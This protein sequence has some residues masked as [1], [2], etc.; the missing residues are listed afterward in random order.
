MDL[1]AETFTVDGDECVVL[2]FLHDVLRPSNFKGSIYL[3]PNHRLYRED[4]VFLYPSSEYI[5]MT[6][7]FKDRNASILSRYDTLQMSYYHGKLLSNVTVHCVSCEQQKR[8]I[9]VKRNKYYNL[10]VNFPRVFEAMLV[11]S[12]AVEY[13]QGLFFFYDVTPSFDFDPEQGGQSENLHR[14]VWVDSKS[15]VSS[16]IYH[17]NCSKSAVENSVWFNLATTLISN[18]CKLKTGEQFTSSDENINYLE[19]PKG[20]KKIIGATDIQAFG[21]YN[22]TLKPTNKLKETN[23]A[24]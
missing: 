16:T 12:Q 4:H 24:I 17:I 22:S 13:A 7:L 3:L 2:Q 20:L 11:T 19:P 21:L 15:W 18:V 8:E 23:L 6:E 14:D 5:K 1:P 10:E 9:K